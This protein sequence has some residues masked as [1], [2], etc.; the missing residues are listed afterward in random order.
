MATTDEI[1]EA[2]AALYD[3]GSGEIALLK[4]V[5]AYPAP[6]EEMH[7]RT[8]PALRD[9]FNVVAGLSD[10]TMGI[11]VPV[12]AVSLGA[13]IVEKHFTLSR[14]DQGPDSAFSLEPEELREMINSIRVV[15]K[16]LGNV[17]FG[18]GEIERDSLNFRRSLFAVRDI[19]QGE[20]LTTKNIRSIRPGFGMHPRH[21]DALIGMR[22]ICTISRGTPLEWKLLDTQQPEIVS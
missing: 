3:N 9:R 11:A 4:C 2:L 8:I 10:H 15:Q 22:A 12:A 6:P 1:E 18:P 13:S 5:S 17:Q 19:R 7:L 20:R 21:Y 16:A 14:G